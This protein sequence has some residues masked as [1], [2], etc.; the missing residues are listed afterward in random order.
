MGEFTLRQLEYFVAVLDHGS[1]TKAAS[2]SNISQAAASMAIAQLEKNL[3]LDLLIRTRAKRVEPTP[4]GVELGVR[5]RRILREAADLQGALQG[6]HQDMRGRV[7]I[8]CM[9]AIS[10]RLIPELIR[11][12]A[13]KWPEVEVDFVEGNAE[14]LQRA[15]A[16]GELDVAFIYSLQAIPG[17]EILKVAAS[18]P[19]FMLA[20][21]HPFARREALRFADLAHEDV[22]LFDVPPSAERVIAMFHSAGIEPKVRWRSVVA[23]TIRGIVASGRAYSVTN[24]WPGIESL[25]AGARVALVPIEDALP[26]NELV[27]VVPPGVSR[28]RRVEEVIAAARELTRQEQ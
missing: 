27:A 8:G 3:G 4:A 18:R 28:P 5:A 10:P 17:V 7:V 15:V 21:D 25:Y 11:V 23:Q 22:V 24:V 14:E 16:E 26:V 9:I 2:E 20:E 12:F 6:S 19:Q 1:L 13:A